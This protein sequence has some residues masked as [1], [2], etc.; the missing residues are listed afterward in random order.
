MPHPDHAWREPR[1]LTA[2]GE[3]TAL[4]EQ[5]EAEGRSVVSING[6]FD[7]L[8]SGHVRI[9]DAAAEQGDI[10]VVGLNSDA[11][12]QL[13]KGPLRPIVPERER[14]E[15]LLGLRAVD[16]VFVFPEKDCMD[17]ICLA[18]PHVHVNDASYGED[19]IEAETV[20]EV[21]ARLHLVEK[22]PTASTTDVIQRVLDRHEKQ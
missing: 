10:V 12:V 9:L 21:G 20:R 22:K 6:C 5:L 3:L 4:R 18:R 17:F 11:S 2:A 14:A 1:I 16:Y 15:L 13:G 7:I 19:C 8:H